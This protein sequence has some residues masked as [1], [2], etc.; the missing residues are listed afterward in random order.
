[1]QFYLCKIHFNMHFPQPCCE[2]HL[3]SA[4]HQLRSAVRLSDPYGSLPTWDILRPYDS[5][6]VLTDCVQQPSAA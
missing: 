5:V 1:M 6:A 3:L 2:M 4:V